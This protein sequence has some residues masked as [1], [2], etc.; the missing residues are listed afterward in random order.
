[1]SCKSVILESKML[2]VLDNS[3]AQRNRKWMKCGVPWASSLQTIQ[4]ND[5]PRDG[6]QN[7][8]HFAFETTSQSVSMITIMLSMLVSLSSLSFHRINTVGFLYGRTIFLSMSLYFCIKID[9]CSHFVRA[10]SET[11]ASGVHHSDEYVQT[12]PLERWLYVIM[13]VRS[14]AIGATEI[15]VDE[16]KKQIGSNTFVTAVEAQS[17]RRIQHNWARWLSCFFS[18]FDLW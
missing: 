7:I 2:A 10:P 11:T 15:E 4:F 17:P 9:K 14:N 12:V 18:V 3:D 5:Y 16:M 1:M 6:V 13:A 8:V